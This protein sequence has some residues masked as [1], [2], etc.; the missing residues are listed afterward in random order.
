MWQGIVVECC[1]SEYAGNM[2]YV[3]CGMS[4][5][6]NNNHWKVFSPKMWY[7]YLL[8]CHWRNGIIDYIMFFFEKAGEGG[9]QM[10]F[11][12]F[13]GISQSLHNFSSIFISHFTDTFWKFTLLEIILKRNRLL[14]LWCPFSTQH[15]GTTCLSSWWR[16][17]DFSLH[18]TISYKNS[19]EE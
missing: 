4:Y 17:Q 11:C 7:I 9:W 19:V 5:D 10:P 16:V 2:G 15:T 12:T 18:I 13:R 6:K 1:T 14:S 3:Q 8:N